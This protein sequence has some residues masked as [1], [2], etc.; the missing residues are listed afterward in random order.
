MDLRLAPRTARDL[1]LHDH[2]RF[3]PDC[4]EYA[5]FLGRLSKAGLGNAIGLNLALGE[6][7]HFALML[8]RAGDDRRPFSTEEKGFLRDLAPHIQ[9]MLRMS[10]TVEESMTARAIGDGVLDRLRAGVVICDRHRRVEWLNDAA[11]QVLRRSPCIEERHGQLICKAVEDDR[12][13][14]S[15]CGQ[16]GPP[17]LPDAAGRSFISLRRNEKDAVDIL[18]FPLALGSRTTPIS[19]SAR[20]R[21]VLILSEPRRG[22][23]FSSGEIAD[24]LGLSPAEAALTAAL[25]SGYS[26]RDYADRRGISVGTARIQ[27][28]R[29]L[30]KTETHRQA[31]LVRQICGSVLG[32]SL[33][34]ASA[35]LM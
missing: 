11:K 28:K 35:N 12:Q 22:T 23:V 7:S 2:D 34:G 25:S 15:L 3:A 21:V 26:L 16:P 13:L 4:R 31:D 9:Q 8:H 10:S 29:V 18:A 14:A 27:L 30:S 5:A 32:F 1:I 17:G 24:L 20:S 6:D 19:R 33:S